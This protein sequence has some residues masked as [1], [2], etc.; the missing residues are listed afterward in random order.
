MT[1]TDTNTDTTAGTA[2]EARPASAGGIWAA[3][4]SDDAPAMIRFVVDVLG[5]TEELVVPGADPSVVV[6]SQLHWPEGGVV[7]VGSANRPG[8]V[9]SERA[10]GQ[11][12]LYVI[13][14]DPSA[15][16]ERCV[17]SGVEIVAPPDSP[18]YDP[19]GMVFSIRDRE[20]NLWSFGTYAGG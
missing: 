10:V 2:G 20:G 8:N 14:A 3:I 5:F 11:Q 16:H 15:V 19:D 7:Q 4:N 12:S 9:F 18:E 17:A 13:T 6:H 1:N